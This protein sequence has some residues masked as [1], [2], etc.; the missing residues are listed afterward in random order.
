MP[1][2]GFVLAS[3]C[4]HSHPSGVAVVLGGA[5]EADSVLGKPTSTCCDT[6]VNSSAKSCPFFESQGRTSRG[7]CVSPLPIT[8]EEVFCLT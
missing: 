7:N 3:R 1:G 8:D 2:V 4:A 6:P 5:D